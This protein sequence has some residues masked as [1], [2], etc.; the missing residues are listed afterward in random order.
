MWLINAT[1][2]ELENVDEASNHRYAILS[3]T[4]EGSEVTFADMQSE[5]DIER[6]QGYWK[7]VACCLQAIRDGLQYVWVDTCW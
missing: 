4:W 5:D 2:F 1:S 6:K 7:V 3:H